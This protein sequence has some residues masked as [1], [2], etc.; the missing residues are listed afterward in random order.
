MRY[1]FCTNPQGS[2]E[3]LLDRAGCVTGSMADILYATG[4]KKLEESTQRVNYRF[5]L[6][7]ER[8]TG[9]IETSTAKTAAMAH[10]SE[11]EKKARM[12]YEGET[13]FTVETSGFLRLDVLYAGCSLDG[14]VTTGERLEGIQEFKCPMLKSYYAYIK[15]GLRPDDYKYQVIHNLWCTGA[16]WCDFGAFR[17]GFKPFIKRIFARDMPIEEHDKV[18]RQ[19]LSEVAEIENEMRG[20]AL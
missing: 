3:W 12:L 1:H 2:Q 16:D 6:A 17:Q 11:L 5:Q 14:F 18:V 20:Y 8:I 9:R 10:G 15:A 13:V 4:R 19:F 7:E